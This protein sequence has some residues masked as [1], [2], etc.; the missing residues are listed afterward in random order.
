[1]K[2]LEED[3]RDLEKRI[4][5]LEEKIEEKKLEQRKQVDEVHKQRAMLEAIKA[6][7]KG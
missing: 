4:K 7:R 1:M 6:R 2:N 3:Q 5:G